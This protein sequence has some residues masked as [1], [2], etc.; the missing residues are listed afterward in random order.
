[1]DT[2]GVADGRS[3]NE[4]SAAQKQK[5]WLVDSGG[6]RPLHA[7]RGLGEKKKL[8]KNTEGVGAGVENTPNA[9]SHAFTF[10]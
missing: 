1:M 4:P 7:Q 3:A 10:L 6:L 9:L 2:R 5:M 8:E